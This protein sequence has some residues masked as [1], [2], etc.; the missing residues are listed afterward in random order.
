MISAMPAGR[1]VQRTL[2]IV[3]MVDL[4][5]LISVF[6]VLLFASYGINT[7]AWRTVAGSVVERLNPERARELKALWGRDGVGTIEQRAGLDTGYLEGL[8]ATKLQAAGNRLMVTVEPLPDA[9]VVRLAGLA[10]EAE[11]MP[12]ELDVAAAAL[13]Q[14]LMPIANGI[15][16]HGHSASVVGPDGAPAS[17]EVSLARAVALAGALR[18]AGYDKPIA[19]FGHGESRLAPLPADLDEAERRRRSARID[20][21]V[22]EAV[23]DAPSR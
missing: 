20:I 1:S 21:V 13:A 9:V 12:A 2:W 11:T 10:A 23:A 7:D 16:V 8:L 5:S 14:A 6:F 4:M 22:R 18:A 3:T 15:E 17:W 19:V